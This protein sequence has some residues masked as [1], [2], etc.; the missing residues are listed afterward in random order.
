MRA[1][2]FLPLLATLATMN[3]CS[4]GWI[5]DHLFKEAGDGSEKFFEQALQT[6]FSGD[7]QQQ[8]QAALEQYQ[9]C[10]LH[11]H[12]G[13]YGAQKPQASWGHGAS[14]HTAQT[15]MH[16]LLCWVPHMQDAHVARSAAR[17]V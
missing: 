3:A 17:A 2:Q 9:R 11:N 5:L 13:A 4:A 10:A 14:Q 6:T 1:S 15:L 7:M 12:W 8:T 16:V